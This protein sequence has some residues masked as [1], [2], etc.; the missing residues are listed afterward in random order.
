MSRDDQRRAMRE[1][2]EGLIEQLEQLYREAFDRIGERDL[3]EGAIARLT[4][5]L[6]R[7]REAAITPLEEEI[8]A[9]LITRAPE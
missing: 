6:L 9:P 2:R 4:Q 8:E 1:T 3:G 5:L 7:S